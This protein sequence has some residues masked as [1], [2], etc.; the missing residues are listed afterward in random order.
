MLFRVLIVIANIATRLTA[1][2][3]PAPQCEITHILGLSPKCKLAKRQRDSGRILLDQTVV[4]RLLRARFQYPK[5]H[6][7]TPTEHDVVLEY[8]KPVLYKHAFLRCNT[9]KLSRHSL[10]TRYSWL[11]FL[12]WNS[13]SHICEFRNSRDQIRLCT[14]R[15]GIDPVKTST[16]VFVLV[17]LAQLMSS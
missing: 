13:G 9:C 16:A 12:F 8:L 6:Y 15:L 5:Q 10:A 14:G 11:T 4:W 3:P 7:L 1:I 17:P 2:Q